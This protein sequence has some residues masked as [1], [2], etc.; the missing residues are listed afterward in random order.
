MKN[1]DNETAYYFAECKDNYES[2]KIL[3]FDHVTDLM[4]AVLEFK[5]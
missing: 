2:M 3:R 4:R 5:P 1:N